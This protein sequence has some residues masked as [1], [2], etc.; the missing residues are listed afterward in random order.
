M[1]GYRIPTTKHA[2]VGLTKAMARELGPEIHV[3]GILPGAIH[4]AMLDSVG[5]EAAA[6]GMIQMLL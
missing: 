6:G 2:M 4:T 1:G 5:G 3:N